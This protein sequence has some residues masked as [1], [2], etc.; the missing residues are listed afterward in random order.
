[1]TTF[2][3]KPTQP[4]WRLRLLIK[5]LRTAIDQRARAEQEAQAAHDQYCKEADAEFQHVSK[6][7]AACHDAEVARSHA[8]VKAVTRDTQ[9]QLAKVSRTIKEAKKFLASLGRTHLIANC[10][11]SSVPTGP[12]DAG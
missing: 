9:E 10:E 12:P 8:A 2:A 5:D 4:I 7:A 6:D 1:M 3:S 11:I